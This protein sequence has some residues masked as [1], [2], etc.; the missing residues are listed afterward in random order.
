MSTLERVPG[1]GRLV[2]RRQELLDDI[3]RTA[4]V[5]EMQ[6]VTAAVARSW[7]CVH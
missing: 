6:Y 7:G 5:V 1:L 4:R 3:V 2:Q